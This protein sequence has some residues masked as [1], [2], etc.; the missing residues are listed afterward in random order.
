MY[1]YWAADILINKKYTRNEMKEYSWYFKLKSYLLKKIGTSF[2]RDVLFL[3]LLFLAITQKLS[4]RSNWSDFNFL[5]YF[6]SIR[7]GIFF[8]C[9][10]R[11]RRE[12]TQFLQ[13]S[14]SLFTKIFTIYVFKI[15]FFLNTHSAI[16]WFC[17]FF[18]ILMIFYTYGVI[19]KIFNSQSRS[20]HNTPTLQISSIYSCRFRVNCVWPTNTLCF[21]PLWVP[22]CHFDDSTLNTETG[23]KYH[24]MVPTQHDV[25]LEADAELEPLCNLLNIFI[26]NTPLLNSYAPA[27]M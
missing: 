13:L 1:S 23:T 22:F 7:F 4:I 9:F 5:P 17:R 27:F 3:V 20:H 19:I 15:L 14:K 11:F 6:M 24:K 12:D 26:Y 10:G 8:G 18:L 25:G 16:H 21:I 2:L